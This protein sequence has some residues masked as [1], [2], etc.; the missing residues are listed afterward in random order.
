VRT[1]DG[2]PDATTLVG[3]FGGGGH[4]RAAGAT[5]CAGLEAARRDVLEAARRLIRGEII[6]AEIT[7]DGDTA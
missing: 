3:I 5:V 1:R 6:A 7:P 4:A 2:G